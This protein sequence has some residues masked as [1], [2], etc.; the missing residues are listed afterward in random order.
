[1]KNIFQVNTNNSYNHR[2]HNELY[3]RNPEAA[4][5]VIETISYLEPKTWSLGPEIIISIKTLDILKNKIRKWKP[6]CPCLLCKPYLRH[7]GFI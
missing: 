3:C 6:D 7:V 1:M 4:K 5:Y 2:S